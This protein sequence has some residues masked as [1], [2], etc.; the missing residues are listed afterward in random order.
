MVVLDSSQEIRGS[1]LIPDWQGSVVCPRPRR[2]WHLTSPSTCHT[3]PQ[4]EVFDSKVGA[5][6]LDIILN[7]EDFGV[8]QSGAQPA[9]SPLFF[10]GSPPSRTANP[11]IEDARFEDAR[12]TSFSASPVP[13]PSGLTSSVRMKFEHKPAAVRIEGFNCRNRDQQHSSI[14][15]VAY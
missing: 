15:G 5:E 12:L 10:S 2:V 4:A 1:V 13:S 9:L 14:P 6:L 3:G 11:L 7:K 8:E